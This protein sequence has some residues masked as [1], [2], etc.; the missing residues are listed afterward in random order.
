MASNYFPEL[1]PMN[2]LKCVLSLVLK[3][4]PNQQIGNFLLAGRL[5]YFLLQCG[6]ARQAIQ[7]Y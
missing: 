2:Q 1:V 4:F 6:Q 7:G 3:L 5:K